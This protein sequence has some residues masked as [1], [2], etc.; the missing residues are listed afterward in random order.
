MYQ[1]NLQKGHEE[2]MQVILKQNQTSVGRAANNDICL[3]D[4]DI[5]RV[6]FI[7]TKNN[8]HEFIITDK[9]TNGTFLNDKKISS[10]IIRP[11]DCIKIGQ[12]TIFFLQ[13]QERSEAATQIID[14]APTKVVSY[15]PENGEVVTQLSQLECLDTQKIYDLT[16]SMISIGKASSNT[17]VIDSEYV[18]NFHCKLEYKNKQFYLKDLNSTNGTLLNNK[19]ILEAPLNDGAIIS[20]GKHNFRFS[21][22]QSSEKI[23][24]LPVQKYHGIISQDKTMQ[25]MFALIERMSQSDANVLIQGETGSGKELIAKAIHKVSSR[26]VQRYITLNCGAIAKDLIESELFGHEKGAFTSALSQR[27]GVFEEANH[28]TLFLDEIAELPLELQPKLLRVLE[29]NEIRRVGSN[30]TIEINTRIIAATHQNL[31][32]CVKKGT[33]REDLYYR[34]FVVPIHVPPLRNRKEDIPLL[35]EHFL[36]EKNTISK[37]ALEQLKNHSWPGNVRELKNL[38]QRAQIAANDGQIENQHINFSPLGIADKTAYEF[39][40]T[41]NKIPK[42][43]KTLKDVEKEIILEELNTNNWNKTETAKKLGIA[44]STLHEKIKKYQLEEH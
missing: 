20:V 12:W 22:E 18:S 43:S 21:S 15:K 7:I 28:G 40:S 24:A 33:F 37:D 8:D 11:Q 36:N 34:L 19:K 31:H 17:I 29:N 10:S 14:T 2:A 13:S 27:K 39:D 23:K 16:D 30:K 44:K 35:V 5:S 25:N 42:V 41:L 3:P 38:I 9:S 6:H 32:E 4:P 1:L 26:A